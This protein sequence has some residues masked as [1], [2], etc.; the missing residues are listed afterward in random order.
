MTA[1]NCILAALLFEAVS[2]VVVTCLEVFALWLRH[3]R[4]WRAY[5]AARAGAAAFLMRIELEAL[6]ARRPR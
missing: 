3:R 6:Y 1:W 5:C 2:K 4:R